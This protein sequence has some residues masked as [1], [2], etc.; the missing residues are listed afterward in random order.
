MQFKWCFNY[1][2]QNLKIFAFFISLYA[3]FY[4]VNKIILEI[5][6]YQFIQNNGFKYDLNTLLNA[7]FKSECECHNN[8]II[9]FKN[10][11][12]DLIE[13]KSNINQTGLYNLSFK[14]IENAQF[15][16]DLYSTFRRGKNL[17]VLSVSLYGNDSYYYRLIPSLAR[18]VQKMYPGW[19]FRV[20]HDDSIRKDLKCKIECLKDE[21]N[22]LIDNTDFCNINQIPFKGRLGQSWSANY[23]HAMEWRWLPIGDS[24]VDIFLSRDSDSKIIQREIDAVNVWLDSNLSGH[25][26]RGNPFPLIK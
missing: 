16:C 1:K 21:N 22:N 4:L 6:I 23:V 5:E 14:F 8:E 18:S 26:M 15:T 7:S 25:I 24:F 9:Y 17:K 10:F 3:A 11:N 19:I 13:I 12:S 2:S 20:Y